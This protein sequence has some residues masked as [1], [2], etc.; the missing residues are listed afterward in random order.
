[1]NVAVV[2]T[3]PG[4]TWPTAVASSNCCS[5]SQPNR[6]TKSARRNARST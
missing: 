5:V 1:M 4:V 3:G 2:K 6:Y